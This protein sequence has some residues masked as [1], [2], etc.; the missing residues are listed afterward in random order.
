MITK[1]TGYT[2]RFDWAASYSYSRCETWYN[3]PLTFFAKVHSQFIR[4]SNSMFCTESFGKTRLSFCQLWIW[5]CI[6]CCILN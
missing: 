6:G 5:P 3:E 2:Y 4:H 1:S